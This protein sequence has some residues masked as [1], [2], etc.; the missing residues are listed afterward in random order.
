MQFPWA[1]S[2]V[3]CISW[4]GKYRFPEK[5]RGMYSKDFFLSRDSN[6]KASEYR[7]K[8]KIGQW[9]DDNHIR[10]TGSMKDY[11]M[12]IWG[13]RHA[14]LIAGLGVIRQNNFFYNEKG[15]WL[16]LDGFLIDRRCRLYKKREVPSCPPNCHNCQKNCPTGAL[17]APYTLNPGFCVSYVT[18]FGKGIVPSGIQEEQLGTWIVGCDACQDACPFNR[19]HDWSDG[20]SYPDLDA[21]IDLLRLENILSASDAELAE[22]VCPLTKDHISPENASTLKISA[23]RALCNIHKMRNEQ[24]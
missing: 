19:T 7:Q 6:K 17:C 4:L 20:E 9:F 18:T 15:S 8:L 1:E 16:E 10:W 21:L 5:L 23:K 12:S 2:I 3:I 24:F 14:A 13:L 22:R 11:R